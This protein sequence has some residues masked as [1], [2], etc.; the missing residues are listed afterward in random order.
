MAYIKETISSNG[1]RTDFA[2]DLR[3]FFLNNSVAPFELLSEDFTN[4]DQP[5]FEVGRNNLKLLFQI[6]HAGSYA[7]V[8]VHAKK[9]D[10]SYWSQDYGDYNYTNSYDNQGSTATYRA[11]QILLAKNEDTLMVCVAPFNSDKVYKGLNTVDTLL[12]NGENLI[13]C[14]KYSES[15]YDLEFK[16]VLSQTEYTLRPFHIGSPDEATL[17]L[18]NQLAVNGNNG[19]YCGDSIGLKSAG[20]AKQFGT[21]ATDSGTYFAIMDDVVIP[22]GER[23]EYTSEVSL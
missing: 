9:D 8:S 19:V 2:K 3:D 11:L 10:G 12:T 7:F 15:S 4:A 23:A 16:E 20:G 14:E 1:D 18:S 17:I 5:I 22:L 21:Y 13:A 6:Y